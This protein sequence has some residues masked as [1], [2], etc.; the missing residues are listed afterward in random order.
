[1][2][3]VSKFELYPV[4]IDIISRDNHAL[5]RYVQTPQIHTVILTQNANKRV[6]RMAPDIQRPRIKSQLIYVQANGF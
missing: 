2:S 1:M 3:I 5:K 4:P 6:M